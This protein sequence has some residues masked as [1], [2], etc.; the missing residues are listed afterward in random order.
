MGKKFDDAVKGAMP[1]KEYSQWS[2][3]QPLPNIRGKSSRVGKRVVGGPTEGEIQK[4]ILDYLSM[5][6]VRA[7]HGHGRFW[8][9]N[10][11]GR[12]IQT[13][14]GPIMGQS[15]AAGTSD[16]L[17]WLPDGRFLAIEVKK[18]GGA[19]TAQ[20]KS[21]IEEVNRDGGIGIVALCVADVERRLKEALRET[22]YAFP[23]DGRRSE[24]TSSSWN[25]GA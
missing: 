18:S 19:I 2:E 10:N 6:R 7:W 14:N 3:R 12:I 17:G 1:F 9:N 15:F 24:D 11:Q 16:I 23:E 20:Q 22:E 21:F 25:R 4:A 13:K 5:V 8:R